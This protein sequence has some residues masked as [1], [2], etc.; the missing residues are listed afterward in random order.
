M[1]LNSPRFSTLYLRLAQVGLVVIFL[2]L[3][4]H[5][6]LTPSEG[7]DEVAHF[8]FIRFVAAHGRLP[9]D[10]TERLEAGYK[11][12][13]PPLYYLIAGLAGRGLDLESPPHLKLTRDNSRLKLVTGL[14]NIKGWRLIWTEDPWRGEVLLWYLGRWVSLVGGLLG[15]VLA[16]GLFR[17]VW[18]DYPWLA[19][20]ATAVLGFLST[21][22]YISGITSYESLTG[23]LMAAY[24]GLLFFTIN[25]P[26]RTWLYFGLGLLL[27]LAAAT[28]Q[29]VWS[30]LPILP[31]LI[32]W[33]AYRQRW[34]AWTVL[35]RLAL[36]GLGLVLTFGLWLIYVGLYFNQ[37]AS[38]GWFW[39]LVSPVLIGDGSGRTSLQIA[40]LAS[41]GA[42]GIDNF[43][44]QNDSF[45]QWGWSFFT[46]VWGHGWLGWLM[47]AGW[48]L[49]LV[50]LGRRWRREPES[51]RLWLVLL[52]ASIG[53]LLFFPL[54][55][56]VFSGEA[57]TAMS[58]HILFPGGAAMLVL[59]VLGLRSWLPAGRLTALLLMLAAL[60]LGQNVA[61]ALAQNSTR[62]P[63]QTVPVSTHEQVIAEFENLSL[64]GYDTRAENGLLQATLLWRTE[65]SPN[66]DYQV[67]LTLLDAAGQ[68]QSAWLGQPLNGR[69]PTRAWLPGDR[70]RDT[71]PLPIAGLPA[72]DYLLQ[73]RLLGELQPIPSAQGDPL[74]VGPIALMP[75]PAQPADTLVLGQRPIGYT[76]WREEQPGGDSLPVY[77]ENATVVISTQ[78]ALDDDAVQLS[79][80][81]PA[82]QPHPPVKQAGRVYNFRIAPGFP[83]GEVRLR[84]EQRQ[85]EMVA[86][87]VETPSLLVVKTEARQ[88]D[89]PAMAQPVSANFAGYVMLL[90]YDLSQV[91]A[92]PGQ[93]LSVT[94]YWQALR[95]IGADL[96]LF[97]HLIGPDGRQWSGQDRQAQDVYSTMFWAP[98]EVVQDSFSLPIP[99]NAPAG[100]YYLLVGLYLPVGQ[101]GVS[102]PLVENGQM[103]D[104]THVAI[105][106]IEVANDGQP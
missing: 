13:L 16:Y 11:A 17:A 9:L 90:G 101:A 1:P 45:W 77:G 8:S 35:G 65:A 94:L 89:I 84:L 61:A 106:P 5:I 2:V 47:L 102:L 76:L 86:A 28:R 78:A 83:S 88:F 103:T 15:L 49:A 82:G 74:V 104:V 87:Q 100:D 27:G 12:D 60:Y 53:L 105:G 40:G 32:L 18:P 48:I 23:A 95:T 3:A 58:Q 14:E 33:L 97:N 51:S 85:D 6:S 96:V 29:T 59:L 24:F 54:L 31:L 62:F 55:R 43:A 41:G 26:E 46:G 56:F 73:L 98:L 44:R 68:P 66:E 52:I 21:Y 37:V 71:I 36:V 63:V 57:S 91:R 70:I 75:G 80:V 81:D 10:E 38:K 39:G 30:L 34:R 93:N 79:L 67:E 25:R 50:G 19:L 69:Y 72:G 64:I 42:I 22:V 20:S 99:A 92:Q 4:I 7:P